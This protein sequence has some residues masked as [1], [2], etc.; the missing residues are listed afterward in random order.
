VDTSVGQKPLLKPRR[1]NALIRCLSMADANPHQAEDAYS[2][3]AIMTDAARSGSENRTE[4][5]P[6]PR[7]LAQN[8]T[9]TDRP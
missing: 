9:E 7:F 5:K 1:R 2:S 4:P 6:K 8:R 3:L